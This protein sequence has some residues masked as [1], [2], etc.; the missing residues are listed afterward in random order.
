MLHRQFIDETITSLS[1]DEQIDIVRNKILQDPKLLLQ[2]AV[3][4]SELLKS[5]AESK[6]DDFHTYDANKQISNTVELGIMPKKEMCE[7][8]K[9]E[10]ESA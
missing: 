9:C 5:F 4:A 8:V 6:R 2:P 3:I 1:F 7:V 10:V